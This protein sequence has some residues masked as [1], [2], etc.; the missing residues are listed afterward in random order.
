[1]ALI[2]VL[3]MLAL[4]ARSSVGCS[5]ASARPR[6][7]SRLILLPLVAVGRGDGNDRTVRKVLAAFVIAVGASIALFLPPGGLQE[8]WDHTIGFQLTRIDVFSIWALHPALAPVKLAVEAFAVILAVAVAFR[9]PARG[10]RP[11]R[12][13]RRRGDDRHPVAGT[14]LVLLYII[15]FFPL[16]LVA[17]LAT[18]GPAVAKARALDDAEVSKT[19]TPSRRSQGRVRREMPIAFAAAVAGA[20]GATIGSFL[21]VV[22]Y[23]LPR[24]ESLV[25]P[26]R[27]APGARPRSRPTTTCRCSA[28]C[29]YA[30]AAAAA[31]FRSRRA[32]RS[33]RR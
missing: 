10:R 8:I 24:R 31:G 11:G 16:V 32:I 17:V 2:V 14:P 4:T 22:A 33:S 15:W 1:M 18:D 25:R 5:S 6:S 27:A 29:G 26:A 23:R 19:A 30:A 12:C 28:G 3:V 13:A 9:P 21:N 20:F 7:S